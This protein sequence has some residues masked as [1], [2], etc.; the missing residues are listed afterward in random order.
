MTRFFTD[1]AQASYT[2]LGGGRVV[3]VLVQRGLTTEVTERQVPHNGGEM[4]E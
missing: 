1:R 4:K 2:Y 3:A